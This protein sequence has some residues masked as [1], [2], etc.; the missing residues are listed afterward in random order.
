MYTHGIRA[1]SD[2]WFAFHI[3]DG[4]LVRMSIVNNKIEFDQPVPWDNRCF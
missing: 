2:F 3:G 4:K 1:N